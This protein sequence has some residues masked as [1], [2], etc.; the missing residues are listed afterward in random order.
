MC[1]N[2][3]LGTTE[4]CSW[5]GQ[6]PCTDGKADTE[7]HCLDAPEKMPVHFKPPQSPGCK[8]SFIKKSMAWWRLSCWAGCYSILWLFT[9][10]AFEIALLLL[11]CIV[12]D[13]LHKIWTFNPLLHS[14]WP[15]LPSPLTFFPPTPH[16]SPLILNLYYETLATS[17][18]EVTSWGPFW[19]W[20][21]SMPWWLKL[22]A[23]SRCALIDYT[24]RCH[25]SSTENSMQLQDLWKNLSSR[26]EQA[27]A[28]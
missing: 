25:K 19:W 11:S 18:A 7:K 8:H 10:L 3:D 15:D 4:K 6:K 23:Q 12:L 26:N 17:L 14:L 2:T 9:E 20:S 21:S 27:S 5:I 1:C 22:W 16:S 28:S 13:N 24:K